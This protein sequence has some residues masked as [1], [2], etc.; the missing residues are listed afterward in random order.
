VEDAIRSPRA[1]LLQEEFGRRKLGKKQKGVVMS[2]PSK[3]RFK[4]GLY[5]ETQ[6]ERYYREQAAEA[7]K[8]ELEAD[9]KTATEASV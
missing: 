4:V 2:D 8:A 9:A 6:D 1:K 3:K 7:A 5:W